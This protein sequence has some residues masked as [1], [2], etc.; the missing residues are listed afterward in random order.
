MD[1]A[2][3]AEGVIAVIDAAME[4]AL[5]V[6]SVE[7][8]YDPRDFTLVPFG[9]AAGLHAVSLAERLGIE[10]LLVPPTPGVLSAY[11]MLIA[12]VR[13]DAARTVLLGGT[14]EGGIPLE[15]HFTELES[16]A[17]AAMDE[18]KVA[19]DAVT[20]QRSVAARYRGQS[21]ELD[22]PASGWV[23]RFHAAHE[24]R[25]GYRR[26]GAVVEAV[27]LRVEAI[28]PGPDVRV[29]I[30]P[31]VSGES[32]SIGSGPVRH[33]GVVIQATRYRRELLA[34]GARIDGP[35]VI[36]EQTAALWLPPEWTGEVAGDGSLFVRR[37]D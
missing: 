5:R 21:Y 16:V 30:V 15:A 6:I 2:A 23:E 20:L 36:V 24:R 7:R 8:G 4:G 3:A 1:A 31:P 9:G 37:R 35:A 33:R 22:V 18:E 29:P 25:F 17:L 27:T 19:R 26:D 10:R 14:A 11:G 32:A 28:S 12:P 13:K 34:S